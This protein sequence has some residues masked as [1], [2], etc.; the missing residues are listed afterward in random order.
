MRPSTSFFEDMLKAHNDKRKLHGS[1]DLKLSGELSEKA[2][3]W[4]DRVAEKGYVSFCETI[5]IGEN[6]TI[7]PPNTKPDR[8]VEHWY[9]EH[10]RYEY[11]TPGWQEGTSYFT[12]TVWKSTTEL[13]IGLTNIET[14]KFNLPSNYQRHSMQDKME[15]IVAFYKPGGNNNRDGLFAVNVCKP[16]YN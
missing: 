11:E 4:A 2:Q 6:I 8:I 7:F 1:P 16:K 5:G 9:S 15:I 14:S 12:Q 13:G 3:A 10:E